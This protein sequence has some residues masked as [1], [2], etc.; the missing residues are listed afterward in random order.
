[1]FPSAAISQTLALSTWPKVW[2]A[3]TTFP[4]PTASLP[5]PDWH[6]LLRTWKTWVTSTSPSVTASPTKVSMSWL[7]SSTIL[8][9]WTSMDAPKFRTRSARK[10]GKCPKCPGSTCN[11]SKHPTGT[12]KKII[13]NDPTTLISTC[14]LISVLRAHLAP[15]PSSKLVPAFLCFLYLKANVLCF[16][17]RN[18]FWSCSFDCS[19]SQYYRNFLEKKEKTKL[20]GVPPFTTI[21]AGSHSTATEV[22]I[23]QF[24]WHFAKKKERGKSKAS[25]L[26]Q[27]K[28]GV[29]KERN[30]AFSLQFATNNRV[31]KNIAFF[32]KLEL[33]VIYCYI[34]TVDRLSEL[35][36]NWHGISSCITHTPLPSFFHTE[37]ILSLLLLM[38][39]L[40]LLNI[41]LVM[42]SPLHLCDDGAVKM[43]PQKKKFRQKYLWIKC[44]LSKNLNG[45]KC[46]WPHLVTRRKKRKREIYETLLK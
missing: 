42:S 20:S 14:D 44:I 5:M 3:W 39:P 2:R 37:N 31:W 32:C 23:K 43:W 29:K 11:W 24:S 27:I 17:G 4:S 30:F 28:E 25:V 12:R 13:D 1:M 45:R 41:V 18:I 10:S 46:F 15:H 9:L 35:G 16:C 8:R 21:S 22:P 7:K 40:F 19:F 36:F 26:L 34:P 38:S 6:R 33:K